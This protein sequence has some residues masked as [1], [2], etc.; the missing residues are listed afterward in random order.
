[1]K[2]VVPF[3]KLSIA[4]QD[5]ER[6]KFG[7]KN[8]KHARHHNKKGA[9][10]VKGCKEAYRA[11]GYCDTHYRM[12]KAGE[13]GK[14]RYEKCSKEGC[15]KAMSKE[16][17]SESKLS[18]LQLGTSKARSNATLS[19][20]SGGLVAGSPSMKPTGRIRCR[21]AARSSRARA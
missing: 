13:F 19:G 21:F 11:K 8:H 16:S 20:V 4:R 3:T 7:E 5:Q 18:G 2:R 10:Q 17:S 15:T 9:C 14:S 1:M 6:T 12:W